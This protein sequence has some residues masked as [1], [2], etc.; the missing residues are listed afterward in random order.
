[1]NCVLSRS[2]V[3][4]TRIWMSGSVGIPVSIAE[5]LHCKYSQSVIVKHSDTASTV[6]T[7]TVRWIHKDGRET[8][9]PAAIGSSLLNVAHRH[10][11]ELEGACEGVCACSTCHV[12]LQKE[13]FDNLPEATEE[14]E[15]ML[16]RA[17]GQTATSR[18]GCQ[19]KLEAHHDGLVIRLPRAT[20]NFYVVRLLIAF[21]LFPCQDP[22]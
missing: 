22:L 11:I 12:I 3:V 14:E 4:V 6:E 8:S 9:T 19:I 5:T 10:G 1:M 17:F 2:A 16:D 20:R 18:L 21:V 7:L 13:A 15:D